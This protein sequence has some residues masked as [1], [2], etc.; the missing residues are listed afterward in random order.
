MAWHQRH[1]WRLLQARLALADGR[2]DLAAELAAQVARDASSRGA[3]RYELIATAVC[4]LAGGAPASDPAA[5]DAVVIGLGTCAAL[6]GWPL[7]HALGRRFDVAT[8]RARAEASAGVIVRTAPSAA[9]ATSF[10]ERQLG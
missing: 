9:A 6:D 2:D 8:W 4:A 1:R 10:V 5:L 7:M 3:R